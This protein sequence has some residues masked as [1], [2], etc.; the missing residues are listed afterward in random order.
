MAEDRYVIADDD[1]RLWGTFFGPGLSETETRFVIDIEAE[2]IV[3]AEFLVGSAWLPM[4]EAMLFTFRDHL[5]INR[6]A[7]QNSQ[8]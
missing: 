8:K 5:E 7:L 1:S 2:S 6:E 3:A 4:D